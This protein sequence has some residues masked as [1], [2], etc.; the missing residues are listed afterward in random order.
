MTQITNK[1]YEEWQKYKVEK[2]KGHVLLPDSIS[3]IIRTLNVAV[4][5]RRL[6]KEVPTEEENYNPDQNS[7]VA[8]WDELSDIQST[9]PALNMIRRIL[10]SYFLQLCGYE[11]SDL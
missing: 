10:E 11:G 2:A 1:E 8:L 6:N 7:Y 9:I 5:K 4:T 3:R